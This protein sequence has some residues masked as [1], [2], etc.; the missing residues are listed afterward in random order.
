M[1]TSRASWKVSTPSSITATADVTNTGTR[2][3]DAVV[4]LY[5]RQDYTLPTRPVK[6]L[7]DF[8]RVPL[9]AGESKT[10]EMLLTPAK[11][12]HVGVDQHFA[13][14]FLAHHQLAGEGLGP[15]LHLRRGLRGDHLI[16]VAQHLLTARVDQLDPQTLAA[17]DHMIEELS[18][19]EGFNIIPVEARHYGLAHLRTRHRSP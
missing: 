4:Q 8:R 15:H 10:V 1:A 6:E 16:L 7:K 14:A 19:I 3:G 2:A 17:L 9:A 5:I 18:P 12:G 11:L 13:D